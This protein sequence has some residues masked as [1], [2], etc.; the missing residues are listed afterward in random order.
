MEVETRHFLLP[1][2]TTDG[3]GPSSSLARLSGSIV[4]VL[5]LLSMAPTFI[6]PAIA[7]I[8]GFLY[9]AIALGFCRSNPFGIILVTTTPPCIVVVVTTSP[10]CIIVLLLDGMRVPPRGIML[11]MTILM[12]MR[13][14]PCSPPCI[15]MLGGRTLAT[16]ARSRLARFATAT[17][18][19]RPLG[20]L[21]RSRLAGFATATRP[22]RSL[23]TLAG[24]RLGALA[25]L[26]RSSFPSM[27]MVVIVAHPFSIVMVMIMVVIAHPFTI[28]MI[29]AA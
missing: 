27:F 23:A 29:F 16:L 8:M 26:S 5:G 13:A 28:M 4:V 14:P 2:R 24:S 17:R 7:V 9:V 25:G 1:H 18:P 19:R 15:I 3:I 10:P 20:T 22:R 21:A 11:I 12:W 6:I